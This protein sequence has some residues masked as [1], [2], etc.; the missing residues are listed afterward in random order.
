MESRVF[1]FDVDRQNG[2]TAMTADGTAK[3]DG[4]YDLPSTV[5]QRLL[6]QATFQYLKSNFRSSCVS[7]QSA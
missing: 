3:F 6:Q 7:L 1:N 5:R 2:S 4:R